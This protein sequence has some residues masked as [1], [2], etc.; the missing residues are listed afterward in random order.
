MLLV[1][2]LIGDGTHTHGNYTL[3]VP[4]FGAQDNIHRGC[5]LAML[6]FF[7]GMPTKI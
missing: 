7:P 5:S 2:M 4:S 1:I 3:R 6:L